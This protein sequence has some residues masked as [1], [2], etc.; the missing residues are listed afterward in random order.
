[1]IDWHIKGVSYGACNCEH[2]CPCQFEGD[3]SH[4]ECKGLDCYRVTSGYFGDVDLTGVVAATLYAWPGPIYKGGGIMQTIVAEGAT[5]EQVDA[6]DRIHRG[7]ETLEACSVF[8]VFHAMCDTV[9]ET[10]VKPIV[11][12]VDIDARHGRIEIPGLLKSVGE[13]IRN[14][15][16]GGA[17]RVQI[18]HPEGIEFEYAEIGNSS[19][20]ATGEIKFDLENTYAQFHHMDHTGAGPAHVR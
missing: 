6:I 12:E 18:R 5:P 20:T 14:P 4:Y 10:L 13:P 9:L 8:W 7:Q 2:W 11:F 17:H 1:M 3:P 19:T 16:D 15:H